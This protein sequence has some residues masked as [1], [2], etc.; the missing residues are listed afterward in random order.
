MT[1]SDCVELC[2]PVCDFVGLVGAVCGYVR[3]PSE[4]GQ[5]TSMEKAKKRD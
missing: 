5:S 2:G 1:A 4:N 3:L